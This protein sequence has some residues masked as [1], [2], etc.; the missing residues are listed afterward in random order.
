MKERNEGIS[1]ERS[2]L[3]VHISLSKSRE[4]KL[5]KRTQKNKWI[6]MGG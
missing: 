1:E 3:G 2:A 4:A 5:T 6:R